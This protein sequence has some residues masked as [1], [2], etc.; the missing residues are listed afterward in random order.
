MAYGRDTL[1][2]R[3]CGLSAESIQR[4]QIETARIEEEFRSGKCTYDAKE[5]NCADFVV[6]ILRKS[7]YNITYP[8]GFSSLYTMPLD[9]FEW[10]RDT[11][12]VMPNCCTELVAYRRLPGS[13]SAYRFSRFPL[14]LGQPGRALAQVLNKSAGDSLESMVSRQLTG[15]MGDDRVYYENLGACLTPSAFNDFD[16][17][18]RRA[19]SIEQVLA[20]EARRLLKERKVLRVEDYKT[21]ME[22]QLEREISCLLDRCY[23]T[24]RIS[25]EHMERILGTLNASRMREAFVNLTEEYAELSRWKHESTKLISFIKKMSEFNQVIE[26]DSKDQK[27][28]ALTLEIKAISEKIEKQI[29]NLFGVDPHSMREPTSKAKQSS[30]EKP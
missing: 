7:G 1:G 10:V 15:C 25:T 11:F 23:D 26:Q 22:Q 24:A 28:Q 18:R 19:V 30:K 21:K 12:E 13:Q 5:S 2:L 8:R 16:R 17:S 6:R 29:I 3:I 9:V 4:M 27:Q 20:A 14:S